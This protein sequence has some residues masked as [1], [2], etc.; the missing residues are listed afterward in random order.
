MP[1]P[2]FLMLDIQLLVFELLPSAWSWAHPQQDPIIAVKAPMRM[3]HIGLNIHTMLSTNRLLTPLLLILTLNNKL[4]R[5]IINKQVMH[6]LHPHTPLSRL[7][8]GLVL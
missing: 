1:S 2:H 6:P 3:E 7:L 5:H 4:L 8:G